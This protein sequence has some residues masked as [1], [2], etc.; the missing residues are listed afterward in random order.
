MPDHVSRASN[1]PRV[2]ALALSTPP[3]M[4]LSFERPDVGTELV[5]TVSG[6]NPP[7][8]VE[9]RFEPLTPSEQLVGQPSSWCN[10]PSA[11]QALVYRVPVTSG[12]TTSGT[13]TVTSNTSPAGIQVPIKVK[14]NI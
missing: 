13:L 7:S 3:N 14:H 6:S 1:N 12:G 9:V 8:S 2:N 5:R 11:G 10:T 4:R